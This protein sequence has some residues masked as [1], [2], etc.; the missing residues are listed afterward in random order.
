MSTR[1]QVIIIDDDEAV[2]HLIT[3]VLSDEG[4]SCRSYSAARAAID[5]IDKLQPIAILVDVRMP[6]MDG[7]QF[8]H[9]LR[10][11]HATM[12]VI[13]MTGYADQDVFR[14]T[15]QYH[16][17]DFLAKPF[18]P[19]VLRDSLK[20]VL[21]RDDSFSDHF[22]ET[23]THR[24]REARTGLGLKQAEVAARCGLSPAQVSQIELRQSAPSLNTLLRLC[25]ALNLSVVEL[26]KGF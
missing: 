15:L 20:K 26:V 13:V 5:E 7:M 1:E 12:P 23:I 16:V 19:Q 25:K 14:Q 6:E 18:S 9:E 22:L 10:K 4:Y 11:S 8:L 17:S 3:R 21:G 24:L 2:L